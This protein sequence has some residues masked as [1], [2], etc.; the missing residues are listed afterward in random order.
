MFAV[1]LVIALLG[2][3][4][5]NANASHIYSALGIETARVVETGVA[6]DTGLESIT[7]LASE[8]NPA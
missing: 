6:L 5:A 3:T 7:I 4:L 8:M 1:L 2:A